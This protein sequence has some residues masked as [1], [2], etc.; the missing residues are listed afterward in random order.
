V[1]IFA[2]AKVNLT[3]AITG[4][5]AD[6]YHV[7]DSLVAFAD[8]GDWLHIAPSENPS[9]HFTGP[10]ARFLP[11][12]GA[13]TS[14][15][16]ALYAVEQ[17]VGHKVPVSLHVHKHLPVG[18]GLGGGTAD[19]AAVLHGLGRLLGQDFSPLAPAL[20]ADVPVCLYSKTCRMQGVGDKLTPHTLERPLPALLVW[21]GKGL[22][23]AKVFAA[24]HS[25]NSL[26]TPGQT[27]NHLEAAAFSLLPVLAE[28]KEYLQRLPNVTH[29]H[30]TGSGSSLVAYT[31][32]AR[33][34]PVCADAVRQQ[35]P[36]AW[37]QPTVLGI[38]HA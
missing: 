38:N 28:I 10:F 12:N 31:A 3:L 29:V 32:D 30:M 34:L 23:T 1:Y 14:V 6:G 36:R 35:F 21:P 17:A 2:P 15:A 18:A 26:S 24:Y 16:K 8:V 33:S 5:R 19:A 27:S 9:I 22:S 20:G 4:K 37:V 25:S 7:L 13:N 11:L